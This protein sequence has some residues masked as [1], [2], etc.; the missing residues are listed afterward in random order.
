MGKWRKTL[1]LLAFITSCLSCCRWARLIVTIG[2]YL[3][4]FL[5]SVDIRRSNE[6]R[7][8]SFIAIDSASL[9]HCSPGK[10]VL[11]NGSMPSW[12]IIVRDRGEADSLSFGRSSR[13]HKYCLSGASWKYSFC[14]CVAQS[15][16]Q[17]LLKREN[18]TNVGPNSQANFKKRICLF[19]SSEFSTLVKLYFYGWN[20]FFPVM[21]SLIF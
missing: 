2:R 12:S 15:R 9:R 5:V 13:G 18:N 4:P 7:P 6:S 16:R 11:E 17:R 1:E 3:D 10:K 14:V 20:R 8:G 19:S 21:I